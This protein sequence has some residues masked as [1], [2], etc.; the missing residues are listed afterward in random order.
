MGG[1]VAKFFPDVAEELIVQSVVRYREQ[2]TWPEDPRL[3]P[4]EYHGLQ[5]I[6]V[7]ALMVQERQSYEK[8]V[9]PEFVQAVV[10]G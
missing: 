6:L 7:A 3:E 8:I 4:P 9:R 10:G 5:D 1:L 2:E